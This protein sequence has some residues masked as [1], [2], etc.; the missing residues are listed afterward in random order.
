MRCVPNV[1]GMDLMLDP[2]DSGHLIAAVC[3][4]G[5]LLM[6]KTQR[7]VAIALLQ[8]RPTVIPGT[9]VIADDVARNTWYSAVSH[10]GAV[11]FNGPIPSEWYDVAGVTD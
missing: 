3:Q 6:T 5:E 11:M 4:S 2:Q 8:A 10:V 9:R 7:L 1:Y